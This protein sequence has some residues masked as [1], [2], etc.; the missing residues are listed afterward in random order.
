M[1]HNWCLRTVNIL[2]HVDKKEPVA[3][4]AKVG[5]LK[6]KQQMRDFLDHLPKD[7][8]DDIFTTTPFQNRRVK[9]NLGKLY[10]C[11]CFSGWYFKGVL[12]V[13]W[14]SSINKALWIWGKRLISLILLL[15]YLDCQQ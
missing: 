8:H 1:L 7:N 14:F 13:C 15:Q 4:T 10:L 9:V 3:I 11:V 2:I 12:Q 6:R 5:T